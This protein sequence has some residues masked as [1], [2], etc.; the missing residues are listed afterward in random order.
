[1]VSNEVEKAFPKLPLI[2]ISPTPKP[3]SPRDQGLSLE[4]VFK[5]LP[6]FKHV[7]LI[8][9]QTVLHSWNHFTCMQKH[10]E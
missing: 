7:G 10:Q 8:T 3:G 6:E 2:L 9:E 4:T 1:M 5:I